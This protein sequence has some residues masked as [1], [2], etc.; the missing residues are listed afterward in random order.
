MSFRFI[1]SKC[2]YETLEILGESP[3]NVVY[4]AQRFDPDL[5][6]K[7]PVVIKLFKKK[8]NSLPALQIESLLR[9]RKSAHLVKALSFEKFNSKPALILEYIFGVNLK[10]LIKSTSLDKSE[11]ACV[12][13]QTLIGLKELKKNGLAHGDISLSNILVNTTGQVFLTDYG[14]SNYK[15]KALYGTKPFSAPELLKGQSAG[16]L[17][18]LFSLGVLEKVLMG[19]GLKE[20]PHL[21]PEHFISKRDP[22]LDP[23][24]HNRREKTFSFSPEARTSLGE[25]AHQALFLKDG[26]PGQKK[27]LPFSSS[28]S[29]KPP[30]SY[31]NLTSGLIRGGLFFLLLFAINPFIS[32]GKHIPKDKPTEVLIRTKKWVYVQMAGFKGYPPLNIRVKKPGSYK[33]KWKNQKTSGEKYIHLINGEKIILTDRDF[34]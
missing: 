34:F 28:F 21:K 26:L 16:F 18:D 7:M 2:S 27:A 25:K 30:R 1:T 4:L 11:I 31:Y 13:A 23:S 19:D 15:N 8:E 6:I 14:L 10:Q 22:L 3:F 32:Y 20:N 9:G 12:L 24:P 33:L 29:L 5:K 17:S